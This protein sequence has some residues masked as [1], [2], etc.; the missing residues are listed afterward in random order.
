M[1]VVRVGDRL[2]SLP[3]CRSTPLWQKQPSTAMATATA[4]VPMV[5]AVLSTAVTVLLKVAMAALPR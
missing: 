2:V 1:T 4:T 3:W 5:V